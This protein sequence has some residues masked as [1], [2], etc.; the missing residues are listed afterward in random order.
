MAFHNAC[1][2]SSSYATIVLTVYTRIVMKL[3]Q[4]DTWET[5][6]AKKG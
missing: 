1:P 6:E 3:G 5:K 4:E 2:S